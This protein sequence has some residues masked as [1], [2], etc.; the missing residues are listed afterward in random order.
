[1]KK[2]SCCAW[3]WKRVVIITKR[4][5]QSPATVFK[6][7]CATTR[8]SWR[9]K[10]CPI[11]LKWQKFAAKSVHIGGCWWESSSRCIFDRDKVCD[12]YFAWDNEWASGRQTDKESVILCL[13]LKC[14]NKKFQ[15]LIWIYKLLKGSIF[16]WL[17]KQGTLW[18]GLWRCTL[19]GMIIMLSV[20]KSKLNY[21]ARD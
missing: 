14:K 7:E 6:V 17:S 2:C 18:S 10:K 19:V 5:T 8:L 9:S 12:S 11:P 16:S 1:M 21:L 3:V 4:W 20:L 15:N 13:R